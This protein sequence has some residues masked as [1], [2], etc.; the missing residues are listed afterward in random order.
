MTSAEYQKWAITKDR[1]T[2]QDWLERLGKDESQLKLIHAS[3]GLAGEVGEVV[4][5]VKKATLYGRPLDVTNIKEECGDILWYMSLMLETVGSSFEEV[6]LMNKYK[7]EARYSTGFTEK[8]AQE[9]K[10]KQ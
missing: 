4:D 2:Y 1:P 6:M 10:D 5:A 9:R 7:L 3:L 8:A